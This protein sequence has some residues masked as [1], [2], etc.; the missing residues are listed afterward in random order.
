M[1]LAVS[2]GPAIYGNWINGTGTTL[3]GTS[4][5]TFA[6]R[7]SQ[8]LTNAGRTFTQPFIVNSPS[9]SLVLQDAFT[10]SNNTPTAFV[11]NSGTLN[12]NGFNFTLSGASSGFDSANTNIRTIAF[13]SGTWTLAGSS[14]AWST[15]NITNLTV[16]GTGTISLTSASAKQFTGGGANY[17][18]IT[19]NQGG[20]GTLTITGN[21]T[22]A[23]ITNTYRATGATNLTLGTTTQTVSSFTATGTVGKVLTI[24]GSSASSP[25]TLIFSGTGV[26]TTPTTD[27]LAITGV[28]AYNLATTWYAGANSTNNGSLGWIFAAAVALATGNFLMFFN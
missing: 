9:G 15:S 27:Y 3:S 14:V 1:T 23:N 18:G 19:L 5:L 2:S 28:R 7:A 25:A 24:Q 20:A 12:A 16:T 6:G 4:T 13:G 11:L 26:A 17:S 10:S 8:T 21:N 22:F